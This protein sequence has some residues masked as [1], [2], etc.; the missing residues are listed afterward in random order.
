MM[1]TYLYPGKT[2]FRLVN[3][4]RTTSNRYKQLF[5]PKVLDNKK[6]KF[7]NDVRAD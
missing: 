2:R 7:S 4:Q 1:R 5:G 6:I 3:S